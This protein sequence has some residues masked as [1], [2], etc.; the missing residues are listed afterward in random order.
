M[1]K[2]DGYTKFQIGFHIFIILIALCIVFAYAMN[3]QVGY[4]IV[5]GLIAISSYYR[6]FK[7]LKNTKHTGE[8]IS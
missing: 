3:F 5:G 8:N 1:N 2:S 4:V 6:L 7:L